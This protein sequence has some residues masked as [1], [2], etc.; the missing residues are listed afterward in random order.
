MGSEYEYKNTKG[1][2][3]FLTKSIGNKIYSIVG[4]MA[5]VV[6]I[7][8]ITASFTSSTLTMV[9][10]FARMERGHSVALSDAKT[11]LYKYLLFN[12]TAYLNSYKKYIHK[13][14][15]YSHIFGKLAIL[16]KNSTS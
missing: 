4:V 12:D 11:N 7:I 10:T 1:L 2:K 6:L 8:V 3:Y 14:H 16:L 13:A 15:S 9:T 5:V